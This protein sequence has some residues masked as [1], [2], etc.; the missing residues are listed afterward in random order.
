MRRKSRAKIV[1]QTCVREREPLPEVSQKRLE[2]VSQ[3]ERI[4]S[5]SRRGLRRV[6]RARPPCCGRV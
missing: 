4:R 6:L 3:G 2:L 5:T 1:A